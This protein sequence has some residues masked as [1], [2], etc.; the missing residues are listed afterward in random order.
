MPLASSKTITDDVTL[1]L[2]YPYL[3]LTFSFEI[4]SAC[5]KTN[6][7]VGFVMLPPRHPRVLARVTRWQLRTLN[8]DGGS[9]DDHDGNENADRLAQ[10]VKYRTTVRE[11]VGSNPGRINTQDL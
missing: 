3:M 8:G 11:V 6:S 9:D 5:T 7:R 4:F 1:T 2:P 10:L